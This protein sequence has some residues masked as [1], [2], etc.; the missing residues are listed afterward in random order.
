MPKAVRIH[1]IQ[2]VAYET[3]GCIEDWVLLHGHTLSATKC[4]EDAAFPE[5]DAFDWLIILGGPMSVN[6][7]LQHPWIDKEKKFVQQAI[8]SGKT[9]LGI[10]LGAQM[11]AATLGYSVYPNREKKSAGFP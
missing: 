7:H 6:D 4:Y 11:I 5:T 10:C 2:H 8:A 3:L 1:Y 9:I